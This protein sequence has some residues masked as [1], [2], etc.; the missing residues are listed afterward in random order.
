[1]DTIKINREN[2]KMIAHRG[3]SGIETENTNSAFVAAANRSYFGIEC[4]IHVT[5]DKKFVVIHDETTA[6]VSKENI[7]VETSDFETVRKIV[8]NNK[9]KTGNINEMQATRGDLIIPTLSE[10][11]SICKKY[12]KKCILELKNR[13]EPEDIKKVA[14]EINSLGYLDGVIFISFSLDNMINLRKLLPN[15]PLQFLTGK[16]N[17]EIL[18]A[19]NEYNLD[20][21]IAYNAL[22]KEIVEELHGNGHLINCWT[23]D[24]KDRV[25]ELLDM[26]V[27]FITTNIL[28]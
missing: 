16:Y 5:S 10:Y 13:F 22:T 27:D 23:C 1:M 28:E 18:N 12:G 3:L 20:L 15:Q 17:E 8:L 4:D 14:D 6:R 11:I 7:N 19:L 9:D 2:A 26:G 25:L 24:D 21:D